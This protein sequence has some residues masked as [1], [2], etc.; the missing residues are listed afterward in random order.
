LPD[1][2]VNN[3][4]TLFER[5]ECRKALLSVPSP[6][7]ITRENPDPIGSGI[8]AACLIEAIGLAVSAIYQKT[9]KD[10]S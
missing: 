8:A 10:S 3:T 1:L 2:S 9:T 5:T 7:K 4:P 6:P